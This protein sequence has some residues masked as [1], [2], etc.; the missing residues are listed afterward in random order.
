METVLPVSWKLDRELHREQ[1][2]IGLGGVARWLLASA[3]YFIAAENVEFRPVV[4]CYC[5]FNEDLR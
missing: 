4:H 3:G 2:R 1:R 5:V